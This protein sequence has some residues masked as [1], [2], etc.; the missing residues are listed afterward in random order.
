MA[1]MRGVRHGVRAHV[2]YLCGILLCSWNVASATVFR[3]AYES[4]HSA[5]V[6][7]FSRVNVEEANPLYGTNSVGGYSL[8]FSR[9]RPSLKLGTHSMIRVFVT[10]GIDSKNLCKLNNKSPILHYRGPRKLK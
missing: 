1:P 8:D 9:S 6:C 10:F 2:D 3:C 7:G 4:Y 5:Q